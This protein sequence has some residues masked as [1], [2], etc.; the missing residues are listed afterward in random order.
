[1]LGL[2][3]SPRR[4]QSSGWQEN[5]PPVRQST[6]EVGAG[7]GQAAAVQPRVQALR[8]GRSSRG[9]PG[10]AG[11][12]GGAAAPRAAPTPRRGGA[13]GPGGAEVTRAV[14]DDRVRS[15]G[16]SGVPDVG[17]EADLGELRCGTGHHHRFGQAH[18][19]RQRA[20]REPDVLGE[21]HA[22]D[23]DPRGGGVGFQRRARVLEVGRVGDGG[24][25]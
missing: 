18:A 8:P 24:D 10:S 20:E 13:A 23:L 16:A 7:R 19:Q 6:P 17:G 5:A 2:V 15:F 11:S 22:A 9:T 14:R 4:S 1:M 3:I 21:P 25:A 12:T